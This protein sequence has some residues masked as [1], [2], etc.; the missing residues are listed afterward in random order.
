MTAVSNLVALVVEDDGFQR[1]T[2]ARMLRSLGAREVRE[3]RDGKEGLA[4]MQGAA[5]VDLV[6]CDLDMPEMDG[7]EF[8]RHL[9]RAN[10]TADVV[11]SSAKDRSL[12]SSVEKMAIA[13]GV[14]LLGLLEKPVTLAGL[15]DIVARRDATEPQLRHLHGAGPGF[16]VDEI[17]RGV[18]GAAVRA[19]LPAEGGACD[20]PRAGHGG[21]GPMASSRTRARLSRCVHRRAGAFR[22]RRRADPGDARK[23]CS[24]LP[25]A[26]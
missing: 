7:M 20:R 15:E 9:G 21:A 13:Y 3:A 25:Q 6:V 5:P 16:S 10:S 1:R 8:M 12:A 23:C 24:G 17:L 14:H 4:T 19:L 2:V 22:R 11:I 26:A 18:Q